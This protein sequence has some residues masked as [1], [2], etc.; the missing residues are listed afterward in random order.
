MRPIKEYNTTIQDIFKKTVEKGKI[1]G[2][3]IGLKIGLKKK[4][5][6]LKFFLRLLEL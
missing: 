2:E 1:I 3:K 6:D 4:K 5:I